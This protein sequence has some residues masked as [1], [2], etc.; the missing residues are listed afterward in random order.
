MLTKVNLKV[1]NYLILINSVNSA[2]LEYILQCAIMLLEPN[3]W[4]RSFTLLFPMAD[5]AFYDSSAMMCHK[6]FLILIHEA[7]HLSMIALYTR[8]GK[9]Y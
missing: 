2:P 8:S 1:T 4:A 5:I 6:T 7:K 9:E 3:H